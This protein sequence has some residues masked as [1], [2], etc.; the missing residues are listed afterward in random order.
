MHQLV[1]G[2]SLA[3]SGAHTA[4][5][6]V[7][8]ADTVIEDTGGLEQGS[9][10]KEGGT[11][12]AGS[13]H[14]MRPLA[15]AVDEVVGMAVTIDEEADL[16]ATLV[17]PQ[18]ATRSQSGRAKGLAT[19]IVTVTVTASLIVVT[20]TETE[21]GIGTEIG[22]AIGT[23]TDETVTVTATE[24]GIVIE[25]AIVIVIVTGTRGRDITTTTLMMIRVPNEG[26]SLS[27][28][29]KKIRKYI[30]R[31]SR[32]DKRTR[33]R[34][35]RTRTSIPSVRAYILIQYFPWRRF[36]SLIPMCY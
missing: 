19:A 8:S 12:S 36:F 13:L 25:T 23:G 31:V 6:A 29:Q 4:D 26:T 10:T 22:T 21:T 35:S 30:H 7:D 32:L 1:L 2:D 16:T 18:A 34:A 14:Q 15:L 24:T 33:A 27:E 17:K 5:E 20:A 28:P 11:A 3:D 9:D